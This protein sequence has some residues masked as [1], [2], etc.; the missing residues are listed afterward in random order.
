MSDIIRIPADP[1]AV[2]EQQAMEDQ[3]EQSRGQLLSLYQE[4]SLLR[5]QLDAYTHMIA[6]L[7]EQKAAV[8]QKIRE[9]NKK[10]E[11]LESRR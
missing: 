11:E 6:V 7:T 8:E 1:E 2:K 5:G 4:S 9:N 3:W 10:I